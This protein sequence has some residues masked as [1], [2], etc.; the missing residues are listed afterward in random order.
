[1]NKKIT[2]SFKKLQIVQRKAYF[3]MAQASASTKKTAAKASSAKP[4]SFKK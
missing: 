3:I 2:D 1:L 4:K